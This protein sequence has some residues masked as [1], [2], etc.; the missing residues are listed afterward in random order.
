MRKALLITVAHS[1]KELD[2]WS[3]V[4]S[5]EGWLCWGIEPN[6]VPA[7][8]AFISYFCCHCNSMFVHLA[9]EREM[10]KS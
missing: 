6:K 2:T 8:Q 7:A 1:L 5:Y 4:E 10:E 9:A 3:V